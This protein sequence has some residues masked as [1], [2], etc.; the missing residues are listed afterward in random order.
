MAEAL[1]RIETLAAEKISPKRQVFGHAQRRLQGVAM[2]EIVALLRQG[3]LAI[4]PLQRDRPAGRNE[5][6]RDQPQQR[7]L[8]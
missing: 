5:Q 8:A 1:G 4:A 6:A 2:A 7:G 3:Q